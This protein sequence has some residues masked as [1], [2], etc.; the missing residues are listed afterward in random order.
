ALR[1]L[2]RALRDLDRDQG[3][4]AAGL[5]EGDLALLDGEDRVVLAHADVAARMELGAALAHDDV[6][7]ERVLPPEALDPHALPPPRGRTA[8]LVAAGLVG[9]AGVSL[10]VA[11][12]SGSLFL[13]G[14]LR[15][16]GQDLVDAHEGELLAVTA[17]APVVVAPALLEDDHL[18]AL[19]LLD[20]GAGDR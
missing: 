2:R 7:G 19:D 13:G 14:G 20:Q 6:A 18:F 4:S 12:G 16:A 8:S 5:V 15:P 1:L 9:E 10:L 3:A 17:L 11:L